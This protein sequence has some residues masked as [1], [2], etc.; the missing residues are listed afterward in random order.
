MMY[1]ISLAIT[2][3]P[4]QLLA[5]HA[6]E[7]RPINHFR[8]KPCIFAEGYDWCI[9]GSCQHKAPP[10]QETGFVITATI[11][12]SKGFNGAVTAGIA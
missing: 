7:K 3:G 9:S 11:L 8:L 5:Y 10:S 2:L 6:M 12:T 1:C 4:S